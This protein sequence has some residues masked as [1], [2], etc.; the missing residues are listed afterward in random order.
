MRERI[1]KLLS[2]RGV[3]S[4]RRIEAW[5]A[6]GRVTVNGVPATAGQP[7]TE[8]DDIRLDGRRL[9]LKRRA[10]E[11]HKG[12]AYHRPAHEDLR[13]A[14]KSVAASSIERLP[15]SAGRR[16]IPVSPLPP[17][18]GGLEVFVTDGDLAAA[19]TRRGREIECEFSV[20]LRG[21][22]DES[23][24]EA[25]LIESGDRATARGRITKVGAGGGEGTNRWL[26]IRATGLRPRELR[27]K[28][29][30]SG[31]EPNRVLRTRLGPIA[32]D[33]VLARGRSR[34]LTETEM[35]ALREAAGLAPT[36]SR[37]SRR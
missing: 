19:L 20:R 16:W 37:T 28:M 22:F 6:A 36:G 24:V 18:D 8:R 30:A 34:A 1:Q 10:D 27:Q 12:I 17:Q 7:V 35:Q 33:R 31:L 23:T 5:V 2:S 21:G 11:A 15:K 3:A 13:P 29:Q 4:R 26:Q 25:K 14:E 32:M 9:R